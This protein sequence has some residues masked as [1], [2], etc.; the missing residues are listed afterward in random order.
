MIMKGSA[1][2]HYVINKLI[3]LILIFSPFEIYAEEKCPKGNEKELF[4]AADM[5]LYAKI[6]ESH[7]L[8][9]DVE[10]SKENPDFDVNGAFILETVKSSYKAIEY[11][12]KTADDPGYVKDVLTDAALG[13]RVGY[14][15]VLFVFDGYVFSCSGSVQVDSYEDERNLKIYREMASHTQS[16]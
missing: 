16:E 14:S 6:L 13:L 7:I 12:K 8:P 1:K 3:V 2:M 15:Y 11:F 9:V 10:V 4:L 5:V